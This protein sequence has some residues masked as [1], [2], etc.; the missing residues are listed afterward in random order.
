MLDALRQLNRV[1]WNNHSARA[2]RLGC[3]RRRH[4]A[5][6]G[7]VDS[8]L[9]LA[10]TPPV[11]QSLREIQDILSLLP[12]RLGAAVASSVE[13]PRCRSTHPSSQSGRD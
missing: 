9:V 10:S 6:N 13:T 1:L 3:D 12:I 7:L 5:S 11:S 4:F 2:V 8:T